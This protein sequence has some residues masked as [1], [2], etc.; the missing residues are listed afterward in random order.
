M[1]WWLVRL[2]VL[3][4]L[5]STRREFVLGSGGE[6][7]ANGVVSFDVV[8]SRIQ[9]T[10]RVAGVVPKYNW[11]LDS[12]FIVAKEEGF[13]ALYKGFVPKVLRLGPGGGNKFHYA[14]LNNQQLTPLRYPPRRLHQRH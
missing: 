4:E 3:W 5:C 9:N 8:K 13:G 1:I 11:T 2:V 7:G 6:T 10:I 12:V 14:T